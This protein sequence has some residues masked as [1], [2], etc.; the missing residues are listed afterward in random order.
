MKLFYTI[1][2]CL[3][4]SV[5]AQDN[6]QRFSVL[7]FGA[8]TEE[9][10]IQYGAVFVL[11]FK[12][13]QGGE[14]ISSMDFIARGTTRGQFQFQYAP[15]LWL[16]GDHLHIPAKLNLNKWHYSLFERGA[17]GD[18]DRIDEY[19]SSFVYGKIPFEM[20]FGISNNIPLR[21]GVVL[22]GEARDNELGSDI[23]KNYQD[24]FYL[25]GGYLLVL[26]KK[27]NDNWPTK[28]YYASFEEIFFGGDFSYHTETLD[29]RF[30]APLFWETSIAL[31]LYAKQSRGDNV[32]L[33]CLAGPD[34]TKRFR[35]VESGIWSDTQALIWQMEFR[36]PL[37]WR[38]AGVIFGEALQSAP[39]FSELFR[40][41]V[42]YAVGFGGRLAL[43]KSE[44]L[45]ARGDLSLVDGKHIGITIDLRESF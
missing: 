29:A 6:F 23:P 25:G 45:H 19:K 22:E 11:F 20:N 8:Y 34:G 27:D 37:F 18:F 14:N 31:G 41:Q 39:Y 33:G 15:N 28:G 35:G 13:F 9:T 32:P 38:F 17:R 36:R 30:Y 21:Y 42:H 44:K 5:F 2:V 4:L 10:K 43:N 24:G 26:D 40:R 16:F 3:A 7:P 12:P 1:I